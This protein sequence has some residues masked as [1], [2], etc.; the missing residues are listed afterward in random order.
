MSSLG[1]DE[2]RQRA[3]DLPEALRG[4]DRSVVIAY[5]ARLALSLDALDGIV[6]PP[7]DL[8]PD[9]TPDVIR[10]QTFPVVWR[11]LQR[12]AVRSLLNDVAGDFDRPQ[13]P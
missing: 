1:P 8:P 11:G 2:L 7:P 10:D 4:Y 3:A 9:L 5:I 12:N 13:L 6:G